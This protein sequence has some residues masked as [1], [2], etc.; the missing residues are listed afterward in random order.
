MRSRL[1]ILLIAILPIILAEI[2]TTAKLK[3]CK[4]QDYDKCLKMEF[5]SGKTMLARLKKFEGL[6]K[7]LIGDIEEVEDSQV[8]AYI[9]D[10]VMEVMLNDPAMDVVDFKV[11]LKTNQVK[12]QNLMEVDNEDMKQERNAGED[13]LPVFKINIQFA[14]RYTFA[15]K[16][17]SRAGFL[18]KRAIGMLK[19]QFRKRSIGATFEIHVKSI[20]YWKNRRLFKNRSELEK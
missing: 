16:F 6:E 14:Y 5:K 4:I 13:S 17:Q 12:E 7:V 8:S 19:S 9:I 18:L 15:L 11:N 3:D 20:L 2:P 10:N 1:A